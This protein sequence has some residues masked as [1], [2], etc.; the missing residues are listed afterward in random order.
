MRFPLDGLS[1][2]QLLWL[3]P[4]F[5]MLHNMEEAPFMERW[6]KRLPSKIH[7]IV[8]TRQFVAAV[9]FLTLVGFLATY[10]SVEYLKNSLG[11]LIVLGIQAIVFFNAF[12][13]HI[14]A[15]IRFR[16]YSPGVVTGLLITFPFSL[17]LFQRA[18]AEHIISWKQIWI[19]LAI[20]PFA[21]V[22]FAFVA[23]QIGKTLDGK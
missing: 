14:G 10:V 19:L 23:L 20:A 4:I 6:S 22:F 17:Y 1:F 11:Y 15:T 2:D 8:S 12:I 13:P 7:P 18:L 3:V 21:M 9:T 5:F 16:M